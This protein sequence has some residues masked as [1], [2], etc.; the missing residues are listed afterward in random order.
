M[1]EFPAF[2]IPIAD[3]WEAEFWFDEWTERFAATGD[4]AFK[5]QADAM[6]R[7]IDRYF[8]DTDD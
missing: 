1:S 3:R 2:T 5:E 8:D 4:Y 7:Y 6:H